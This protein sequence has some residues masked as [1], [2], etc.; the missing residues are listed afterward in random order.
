MKYKVMIVE[1]EPAAA[2]F[3]EKLIELKCPD[4][5]VTAKAEDGAK[6]LELLADT[7]VDVVVSDIR[8]PGMDGIELAG[9]LKELYPDILTVIVSGH[10]EF[11]YAKGAIR[12]GVED[13]LLKPLDPSE[14]KRIF[15]GISRKLKRKYWERRNKV[16]HLLSSGASEIDEGDMKRL[17][18]GEKWNAAIIRRNGV[19]SRFNAGLNREI[20]SDDAEQMIVYGRDDMEMLFLCADDMLPAPFKDVMDREFRKLKD[21]GT[22]LTMVSCGEEFL[23]GKLPEIMHGL[24]LRLD[25]SIIIGLDQKL[26]L[27]DEVPAPVTDTASEKQFAHILHLVERRDIMN[28]KKELERLFTLWAEEKRTQFWIEGKIRYLFYEMRSRGILGE[29]NEY[30]LDDAFSEA[31]T[32]SGLCENILDILRQ[33]VNFDLYSERRQKDVVF[34]DIVEYMKAHLSESLSVQEICREVGVSQAALSRLFRTYAGVPYKNYLTNLRIETAKTI[35][36]ENPEIFI[37]DVAE[38]VGFTDQFYFSRVF[39][40]VTGQSPTEF[41]ET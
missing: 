11:E 38:Y 8:M 16:L 37:K 26:R 23:I 19:I 25:N 3:I 41:L 12:A 21:D 9:K 14:I 31:L 35:L 7:F 22:Y 1:D 10:Q 40:S 36:K 27:S 2:A 24:Y 32:V 29:W 20:Y 18:P 15:V 17:F 13:Y 6:A 28:L 33:Y 30:W 4:Y 34:Q 39:R 5:E